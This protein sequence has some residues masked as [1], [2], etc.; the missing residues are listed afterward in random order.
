MLWQ[1]EEVFVWTHFDML[2]I[3]PSVAS[4]QLNIIPSLRPIRQR[5]RRFHPE[6][7][8][9]IQVEVDKLLAVGFIREV[10]YLD[11]LANVVVVLKK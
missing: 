5:V 8:K 10:K 1:N 11:W 9:I 3:H 6:R 2:E 7:Q 4:H